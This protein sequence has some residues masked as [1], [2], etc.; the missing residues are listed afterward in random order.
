[1]TTRR[2]MT[3]YNGNQYDA[4]CTTG[5]HCTT[6]WTL[7]STPAQGYATQADINADTVVDGADLGMLLGS[8]GE[9]PR[10]EIAQSECP[11]N[12]VSP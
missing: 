1:M 12:L 8:W 3:G 4:W 9:A 7:V 5:V 2:E 10:H 11:L 6:P